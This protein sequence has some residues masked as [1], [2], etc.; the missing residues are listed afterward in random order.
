MPQVNRTRFLCL[1]KD[2]WGRIGPPWR[3]ASSPTPAPRLLLSS[4]GVTQEGKK[5]STPRLNTVSGRQHLPWRSG[6][7]GK[8]TTSTYAVVSHTREGRSREQPHSL[9]SSVSMWV[10]LIL[11]GTDREMS[12]FSV[13]VAPEISNAS[14]C[15]SGA[16]LITCVCIAESSSP[17]RVQ[18]LLSGRILDSTDMKTHGTVTI[19]ILR[20]QQGPHE[21]IH[22]L[23]NST[24]GRANLTLSV[25]HL[26]SKG[27]SF[28]FRASKLI[29]WWTC[30]WFCVWTGARISNLYI[31]I[32]VGGAMLLLILQLL[33][34]CVQKWW[35]FI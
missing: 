18:F 8:T 25:I 24:A 17:S 5:F 31:L 7:L 2:R 26:H 29:V 1:S 6:P 27:L 4:A 11:L 16:K 10:Q 30:H 35:V 19:G 28:L 15:T 23:A 33:V 13:A 21:F 32:A 12:F 34:T 3:C 9:K 20:V 14:H 22:C